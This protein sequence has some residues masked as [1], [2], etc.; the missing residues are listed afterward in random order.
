M[1]KLVKVE[2]VTPQNVAQKLDELLLFDACFLDVAARQELLR[3]IPRLVHVRRARQA[4]FRSPWQPSGSRIPNEMR[5]IHRHQ[6][7]RPAAVR[8]PRWCGPAM[9][10]R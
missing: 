5:G 6:D 10:T 8:L 4:I 3:L 1:T 9:A 2:V 7:R